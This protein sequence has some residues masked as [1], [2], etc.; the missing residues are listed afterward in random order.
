MTWAPAKSQSIRIAWTGL[1]GAQDSLH[2]LQSEYALNYPVQNIHAAWTAALG[3]YLSI[4][5]AVRI[6]KPYQ[7]PGIAPWNANPYPVW[8]ASITHDSGKLRP[9]LRLGNLSNTGYQEIDGVA[10]PGRS[11][12]GGVSLWIGR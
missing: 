3:R 10:M 7:Q 9:Y 2:S 1:A 4:T 11:I 12:T 6:A 8:S 5:N